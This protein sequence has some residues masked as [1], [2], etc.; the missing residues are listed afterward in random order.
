MPRAGQNRSA[1]CRKKAAG[2]R[3]GKA[4]ASAG[5]A[6]AGR[7][8]CLIQKKCLR[9]LKR[10][11]MTAHLA[12]RSGWMV[13][14]NGQLLYLLCR[15]KTD[16]GQIR[17]GHF[18]LQPWQ[19]QNFAASPSAL[20]AAQSAAESWKT[21]KGWQG[22]AKQARS[23]ATRSISIYRYIFFWSAEKQCTRRR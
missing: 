1:R 18:G 15:Q 6:Q 10:Q 20:L 11:R 2:S 3:T 8:M 17:T 4:G 14:M 13:Q 19:I 16:S 23:Q 12:G 21:K 5:K 22:P 7:Q 9:P